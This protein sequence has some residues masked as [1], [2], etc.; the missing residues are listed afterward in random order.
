[1]FPVRSL[2]VL[3]LVLSD[4]AWESKHF[5]LYR[6]LRKI[7]NLW[8]LTTWNSWA[9]VVDAYATVIYDIIFWFLG[10]KIVQELSIIFL[11][12]FFTFKNCPKFTQNFGKSFIKNVLKNSPAFH[13]KS[14]RNIAWTFS[15]PKKLPQTFVQNVIKK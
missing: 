9:F 13:H 5:I 2:P 4:Q 11:K 6:I 15:R 1:M 12:C 8:N 10:R 7:L 3:L 14:S